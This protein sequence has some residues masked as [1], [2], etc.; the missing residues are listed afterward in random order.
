MLGF[1]PPG[2]ADLFVQAVDEF[3][4]TGARTPVRVLANA[5]IPRATGGQQRLRAWRTAG[6]PLQF[7]P[8]YSPEP[9]KIEVLGRFRKHSWLTPPDYDS[10]DTL[11]KR[12]TYVLQRVGNDP[13]STF[14]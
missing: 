13:T 8:A 4:G 2:A 7:L 5:S 10:L 14:A 3:L 6:A 9:N 1:Y 12:L 11:H